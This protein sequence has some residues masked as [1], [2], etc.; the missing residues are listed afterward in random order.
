MINYDHVIDENDKGLDVE[1]MW[2]K[3]ITF[4]VSFAYFRYLYAYSIVIKN[5]SL[6]IKLFSFI[7]VVNIE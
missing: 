2:R 4:R 1:K 5:L 6:K 3:K 7:G